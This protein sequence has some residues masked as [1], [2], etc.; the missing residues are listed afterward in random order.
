MGSIQGDDAA[1]AIVPIHGGLIMAELT[2][3]V[4]YGL[5]LDPKYADVVVKR[6]QGLT[7]RNATLR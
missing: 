5:E 6:W 3:R 1:T 7:G 2:K 4:C